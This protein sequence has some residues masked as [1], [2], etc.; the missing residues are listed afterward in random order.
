ML[1]MG[2]KKIF[3]INFDRKQNGGWRRWVCLFSRYP[4]NKGLA[5]S[6]PRDLATAG[7]F[8]EVNSIETNPATTG[9]V[10]L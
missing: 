6:T 1:N 9:D 10:S 2:W 3:V 4:Y 5:F 7:A 8:G